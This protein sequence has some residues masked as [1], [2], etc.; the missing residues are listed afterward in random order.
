[1]PGGAGSWRG[2]LRGLY[3]I[4]VQIPYF[5]TKQLVKSQVVDESALLGACRKQLEKMGAK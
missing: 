3:I 2:R 1:V 4:S 5:N